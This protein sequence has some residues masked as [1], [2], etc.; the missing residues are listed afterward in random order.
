MRKLL[1]G[2]IPLAIFGTLLLLC[3]GPSLPVDLL[4]NLA[5]GWAFYGYQTLPQVRFDTAG[6][7]TAA[8]C[9]AVFAVGLHAF[10][11]WLYQH[12]GTTRP[13]EEPANRLWPIRW[14]GALLGLIVLMFLAGLAAVGVSHQT[15]W[16]LT[17]PELIA[18][19]S[20]SEMAARSQ[21]QVN[22]KWMALA[23][24]LY[25]DDKKRLPPAATWSEEGQPLLSWRV[26]VLPYLE[27]EALFKEFHLEE[28]W[29]SPHNLRLLPRMPKTYASLS[30]RDTSKSYTT[31]YQVFTGRGAAFEERRGLHFPD[32]FL[33]D[34]SNTFLIV[35]ATQAVPWTKPEDLRFEP[36]QRLPALG[37]L[38][39]D[40]FLAAMADGSVR[41]FKREAREESLRGLVTRN[42]GELDL[43]E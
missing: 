3:V 25:H 18:Q 30:R 20:L 40:S 5:F 16:L 6:I 24:H 11:R 21:S 42:G 36:G 4:F 7:L 15:A 17:S 31:H 23:M 2:S 26:L 27:Q 28:P 34:T 1:V 43:P 9:L 33:D 37:N 22:L 39:P 35:E 12:M 10:L 38:I 32:D 29:D 13:I 8:V 41:R 14:T 19:G